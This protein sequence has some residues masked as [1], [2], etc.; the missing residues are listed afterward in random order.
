MII[1]LSYFVIEFWISAVEVVSSDFARE[2]HSTKWGGC[3]FELLRFLRAET[4]L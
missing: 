2:I 3:K 1:I 4:N